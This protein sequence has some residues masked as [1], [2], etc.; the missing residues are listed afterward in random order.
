MATERTKERHR[1]THTYTEREAF[2]S[3]LKEDRRLPRA[4]FLNLV[5]IRSSLSRK[6]NHSDTQKKKDHL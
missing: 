3:R 2:T 5:L 4:I 6:W 1:H